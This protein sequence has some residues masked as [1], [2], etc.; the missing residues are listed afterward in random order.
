M[1]KSKLLKLLYRYPSDTKLFT[2]FDYYKRL[3]KHQKDEIENKPFSRKDE[4][5]RFICGYICIADVVR[6]VNKCNSIQ[7]L[8]Q[9]DEKILYGDNKWSFCDIGR[10]IEKL[11]KNP[12]YLLFSVDKSIEEYET[13]IHEHAEQIREIRD[14]RLRFLKNYYNYLR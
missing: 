8:F 5:N 13:Y 4:D 12:E 9:I 14:Q 6:E 2:L 3:L 10:K 7:D 1:T 11:S